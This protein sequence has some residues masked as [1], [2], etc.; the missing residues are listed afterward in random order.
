[1]RTVSS[2]LAKADGSYVWPGT[3]TYAGGV[4]G[5]RA[6]KSAKPGSLCD[7]RS[8]DHM[9]DRRVV[10]KEQMYC[11]VWAYRERDKVA[12]AISDAATNAPKCDTQQ[13][14]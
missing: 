12:T 3:W 8:R 10:F 11:G 9:H 13:A 7:V 5:V 1:V 4:L 6:A 14:A 2:A